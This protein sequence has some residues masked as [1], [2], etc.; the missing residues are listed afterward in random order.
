M[1]SMGDMLFLSICVERIRID[2]SEKSFDFAETPDSVLH[3][4]RTTL[5]L[6]KVVS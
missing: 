2:N 1:R 4:C 6:K 5:S 3:L